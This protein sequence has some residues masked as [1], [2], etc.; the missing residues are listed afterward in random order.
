MGTIPNDYLEK[1]YSGIL[2]KI[3]GVR[4]GAPV[5][6]T[7]WTYE[8]IK[9]TYG[10]IT[11]YIKDYKNFAADDDING[12][13]FFIRALI[14]YA[15]DRELEPD[16][17]G[18]TWLNYA[19]ENKGMFWWGGYGVSTEHTAYLNLK[20]GIKAP[21]SGSID[22]NGI[23]LAE[24]IGGQIFID[25]WGLVWPLNIE[26]AAEYAGKAASVSHDKNG[27]YGA[28]F[29][30]ACISKAFE[31]EDVMEIINSGLGV[32]PHECEY[33]RIIKSVIDFYNNN[34]GDFRKC[35]DYLTENWGYD[36]YPGVCHIIPN[37]GV[38]ILSL[39][40]G[41]GDLSRTVEIATMCGWDT[42][43]NAGNV[44]T[45]VGVA[46]GLK[47]IKDIYRKPIN[48]A[49][50]ASSISGYLNIIDIPTFSKEL[51][52][53]G[54]RLAKEEEPECLHLNNEQ[55]YFD[56]DL[57]GSTHG[58]RSS[59]EGLFTISHTD[60]ITYSGKGA[61]QV[62]FNRVYRG[63]SA[64]IYY[65]PYYRREDFDDERY[66]PVFSP[67]VYPGQKVSMKVYL[68]KWN[69]DDIGIATYVRDTVTKEDIQSGYQML[70]NVKWHD[71][72]F[73][74][75]DTK[76]HA[77][78]EIGI[79]VESFTRQKNK[80]LGRIIIDEFKVEGKAKYS[81]D[82][83]NESIE[84]GCVTPFSHNKGA[85]TLEDGMMHGMCVDSAEAYTGNY[86]SRDIHIVANINPQYGL[87][88]NL[89]FRVKGAMMGYHVGF[90]GENQVSLIKNDH[91][92]KRLATI[93][94]N[95]ELDKNYEFEVI[96]EKNK[97][98][99]KINGEKII[100]YIDE[101]TYFE[102]GM[103]GFSKFSM[104]RTRYGKIFIEEL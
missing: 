25:S 14:D 62:L 52:V 94:Y 40:Y 26:K 88:H 101:D 75:P 64:K 60:E 97:F 96:A 41:E 102:Y 12:P 46:Q 90:D 89:A 93:D 56:F 48:D 43:C 85:W 73:T 4:L 78:D 103:F 50:V 36:R 84:F 55:I 100:E 30:A 53:L 54:Y 29:I 47:G 32:I 92:L 33:A 98:V 57:P 20:K 18:K 45:I 77:I 76:G 67:L 38:C 42:D 83:K 59:D 61:L 95:W 23:I 16:D 104:G 27:I 87:S 71:I 22:L 19:R 21:K 44:G 80:N 58:F 11:S 79:I 1:V 28:R 82:F 15:K 34:A 72:E 8:K 81:I 91:G 63:K 17:V 66:S 6:P 9:S 3:I 74:V 39:L 51:A 31:T 68:D 49:V 10:D 70:E 35:R 24:Q 37:A 5:E 13:V 2:G 7:I 69:G 65:K 86:Y 99:F